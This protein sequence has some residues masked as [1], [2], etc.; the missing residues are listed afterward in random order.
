MVLSSGR[1]RIPLI[2]QSSWQYGLAGRPR[3]EPTLG[4]PPFVE[5]DAQL[6]VPQAARNNNFQQGEGTLVHNFSGLA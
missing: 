6:R 1:G 5:C 4:V 3:S 2:M